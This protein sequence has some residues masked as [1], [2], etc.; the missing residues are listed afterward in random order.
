MP[1]GVI[2]RQNAKCPNCGSLERHRL[3]IHFITQK[4][5]LLST[6][7]KLLHFAPEH[8][9]FQLF[10]GLPH[11]QYFPVDFHPEKYPPGT[12][13]IDIIHIDFPKDHFDA[14]ICNHVLEHIPQDEQAIAELYRVLK[15]GGWAILQVPLDKTRETTYEDFSITDPEA[16][17]KAF[18]QSDHVRVYGRDYKNRLEK[19]GFVVTID[20]FAQSF[21][22]ADIQRYGIM[23]EEDIYLCRKIG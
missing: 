16:R 20:E 22:D 5:P 10:D 1:F 8:F 6:A 7:S 21:S 13:F 12:H 4:T 14:I 23:K 11:L 15:P 3:Q 18:G 9:F 2:K 19:A 17:E